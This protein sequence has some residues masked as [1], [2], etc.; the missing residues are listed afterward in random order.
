DS[1]EFEASLQVHG[2]CVGRHKIFRASSPSVPNA[3]A[4]LL[5]H[6]R[7]LTGT[8]PHA[9]FKWIEGNPVMN[10]FRFLFFGEGDVAP[11]THE[12]LRKNISDS[13]QRPFVHVT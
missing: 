8:L 13:K 5:I 11:V 9:Y 1:S 12:I 3:V 2:V 6:F 4:A 10:M 7:D